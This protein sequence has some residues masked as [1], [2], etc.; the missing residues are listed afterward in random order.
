MGWVRIDDNFA[1]HPKIIGL[2]DSAFRL[3][4]QALCYSNRQ[5][6]DGFIATAVYTRMSSLD[7]ADYLIEAGL[8]EEVEGGYQIRSYDE[9]QPTKRR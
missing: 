1:D 5:L 6:T 7:E 2:S 9:Y 8:W 3:Y 4:I